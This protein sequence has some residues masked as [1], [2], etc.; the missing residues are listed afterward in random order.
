MVTGY[1]FASMD[2]LQ[3]YLNTNPMRR[4]N[5]VKTDDDSLLI[6]AYFDTDEDRWRWEDWPGV[7]PMPRTIPG[8]PKVKLSAAHVNRL[9]SFGVADDHDAR[10]VSA[11]IESKFGRGMRLPDF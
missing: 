9:K 6:V 4:W 8:G 7:E 3:R 1:Y 10:D 2:T 11:K 5:T